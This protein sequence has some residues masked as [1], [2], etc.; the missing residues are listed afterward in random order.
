MLRAPAG[1]QEVSAVD[2]DDEKGNVKHRTE[3]IEFA[4][5]GQRVK[6]DVKPDAGMYDGERQ[7]HA[8]VEGNLP[9]DGRRDHFLIC[10]DAAQQAIALLIIA[11]LR[12]LLN[13]QHS[14]A[15]N[16]KHQRDIDADKHDC[17]VTADVARIKIVPRFPIGSV[18]LITVENANLTG[19][20]LHAGIA[21]FIRHPFRVIEHQRVGLRRI[22]RQQFSRDDE[23]RLDG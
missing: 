3:Q 22:V 8:K 2:H 4:Q 23:Q 21:D 17:A 12:K 1:S 11:G 5:A 16:E 19:Q 15:G 6:Y 20:F 10:A 9:S 13:G 14:G 18:I 7:R